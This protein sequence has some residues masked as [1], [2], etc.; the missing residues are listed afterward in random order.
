MA[1]LSLRAKRGETA[2]PMWVKLLGIYSRVVKEAPV[3][4][5][6]RFLI[7]GVLPGEYVAV[8]VVPGRVLKIQRFRHRFRDDAEL[9]VK[10]SP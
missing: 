2:R 3:N 9:V 7:E 6:G 8:V 1:G 10:L 5:N 4:G